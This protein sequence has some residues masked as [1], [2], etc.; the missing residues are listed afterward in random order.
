MTTLTMSATTYDLYDRCCR[1]LR[2]CLIVV[3]DDVPVGE[4]RVT[5]EDGDEQRSDGVD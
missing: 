2:P 1:G 3:D 4:I 5:G